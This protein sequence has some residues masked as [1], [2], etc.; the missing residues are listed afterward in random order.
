MPVSRI[1]DPLSVT[2]L[3]TFCRSENLLTMSSRWKQKKRGET[4]SP[5]TEKTEAT[6]RK[7]SSVSLM[8]CPGPRRGATWMAWRA[9]TVPEQT[10]EGGATL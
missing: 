10:C 2:A 3:N 7:M 4:R 1:V 6:V 5:S 9:K 8:S